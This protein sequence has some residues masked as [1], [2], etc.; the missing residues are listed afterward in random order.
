LLASYLCLPYAATGCTAITGK[1]SKAD[2]LRYLQRNRSQMEADCVWKAVV[3]ADLG[4]GDL[5]F[6]RAFIALLDYSTQEATG[7]RRLVIT[8]QQVTYPALSGLM[9]VGKAAQPLV[10]AALTKADSSDEAR[11]NALG[12]RLKTGQ[13]GTLQNRPTETGKTY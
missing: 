3:A 9:L 6:A 10:L 7:S 5:D 1:E 13:S 8:N 12:G 2:L 4:K 11:K